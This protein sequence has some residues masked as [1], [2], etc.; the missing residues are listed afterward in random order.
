MREALELL[1]ERDGARVRLCSPEVG[2]LCASFERGAL[3]APGAVVGALAT[4][5][6]RRALVVPAGVEGRVAS[7]PPERRH[8]PLGYREL[9]LELEELRGAAAAPAASAAGTPLAAQE[10]LIVR[11]TSS[12]RFWHRSAPGE[13]PLAAVGTLVRDGSAVGLLE[14]MKTFGPVTYRATGGLP[15]TARVVQ[16]LAADGADVRRGDALLC[17]E[18]VA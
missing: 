7:E 12:G 15:A 8:H 16:V 14:V 4:L 10:R 2:V 5:G 6:V 11:A 13:P 3:L 1:V 9:V 17:V 18:A